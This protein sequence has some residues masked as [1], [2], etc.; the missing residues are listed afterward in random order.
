MDKLISDKFRDLKVCVLVPTY[1]NGAT[2]ES[3]LNSI[4]QYT[5]Q[6][7]VVNDGSNDATENILGKFPQVDVVGYQHNQGKGYALRK[8]FRQA[9]KNGYEYAIT[10]DSD[11][12]HYADD[13][14]QFLDK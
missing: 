8:G 7:I 11:G 13:L 10:I 14:S 5:D 3:V 4:L 2:L 12:Q 1:N 6:V 9:V